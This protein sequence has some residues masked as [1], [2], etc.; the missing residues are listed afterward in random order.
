[1]LTIVSRLTVGYSRCVPSFIYHPKP[2]LIYFLSIG[3]ERFRTIAAAYYRGAHG[4][5]VVY[6]VTDGGTRLRTPKIEFA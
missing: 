6:D 2:S 1:M 4:I 5:I 3:Q